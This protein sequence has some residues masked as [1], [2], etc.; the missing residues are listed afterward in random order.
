MACVFGT[1]ITFLQDRTALRNL[2]L[3]KCDMFMHWTCK[4]FYVSYHYK[5]SNA[6][7]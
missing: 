6:L 7:L 4:F 2:V 1:D 5:C 3:F